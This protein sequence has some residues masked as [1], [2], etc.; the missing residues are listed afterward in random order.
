MHGPR[1]GRNCKLTRQMAA[2]K[3][4]NMPA[5]TGRPLG[6]AIAWLAGSSEEA[7]TQTDH[8]HD[9]RFRKPSLLERR[10]ARVAFKELAADRPE[11]QAILDA[12][13]PK[14]AGEDSEPEV[15]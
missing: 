2:A 10:A 14:L 9:P 7:R 1:R 3:R 4:S 13:R 11:A 15:V 6:L 12:E 8:V 5:G